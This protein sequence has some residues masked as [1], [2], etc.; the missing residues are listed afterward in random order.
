MKIVILM[1]TL[2]PGAE[3][4]LNE[5]LR[6]KEVN[7]IGI[8]RSDVSFFRKKYWQYVA[9]GIR[10]SG[11]FYGLLI[12]LMAYLH[13]IGVILASV[14]WW[15]RK[16]RWLTLNEMIENYK[17][18][19][20]DTHNINSPETLKILKK[21][22]PDILVSLYFDQILKKEAIGIAKHATINMHPGILPKYRGIWPEFWKL[23]NKEKMAGVTIHHL[24]EKID[25]GTVIGQVQYPIKKGDTRFSLMLKSAQHGTKLLL[26]TLKKMKSNIHLKPLKLKGKAK[27]YSLPGR[28]HFTN[29]HARGKRLFSLMGIWKEIQKR[30]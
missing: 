7:V 1:P 5:I 2:H 26:K 16:R 14:L 17:L 9:Y 4:A 15:R 13:V 10:R 30:F 18:A 3:L 23:Y 29:F 22:G 28:E 27:Y 12:A 25:D 8:V 6:K 19:C 24:N 11:I 21:W 20:H